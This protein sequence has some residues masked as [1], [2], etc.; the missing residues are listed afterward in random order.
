MRSAPR[1]F[2][3]VTALAPAA[4]AIAAL[5][6]LAPAARAQEP[7]EEPPEE[8]V[9]VESPPAQLAIAPSGGADPG[10]SAGSSAGSGDQPVRRPHRAW[11]DGDDD[12]PA[13]KEWMRLHAGPL[14][15]EPVVLMQVQGIPYVG[16]DSF[17]EAGDP[18]DRPGFRLRRARFGLEGRL[19][20]RVPWEITAEV[21]TD[22]NG[23]IAIHDAWF[24]YDQFKFLQIFVGTHDVPFSRYAVTDAGSQSLIERPF[25]VRAMAPFH[26]L[27]A[28]VEGHFFGGALNYYA[29]VYNALQRYDQF[30][31]GYQ[32]NAAVLGN[33]F[34]GL[35]YAGRLTSEPLGSIGSTIEDLHHGPFRIAAGA[36]TFYSDGGS[37]GVLG[38]GGDLL[39]HFRG[40]HIVAEFLANRS[41]PKTEPTVPTD[42]TATVTSYGVVGEAGYMILKERLGLSARF[43]Y[44]DAN[45]AVKDQNDQWIFT[46]GLSYHVLHDFLKAGIDYTHR[47]ELHGVPLTN[48]SLVIQAQ[49][50]L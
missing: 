30:W 15:V 13:F 27:G 47:G 48:D 4:A 3:S 49:L 36:S 42:Q 29:G 43:E 20:H 34:D 19:F 2:V 37:R 18:A 46:G 26:Q 21:N 25:A 28:H 8:K 5:L 31:Q 23:N 6:T 40:L 45:T 22:Q 38:L 17:L 24:G 35:S 39:I 32:E 33:R 1:A 10:S 41:T 14:S 12:G 9:A 50:K 11:D 16:A 44:I 7:P